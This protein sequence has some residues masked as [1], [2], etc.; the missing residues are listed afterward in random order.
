LKECGREADYV[1][2]SL[3]SDIR[4]NPLN[5][6]LDPYAQAFN[7]A[8]IITSI[9]GKGKEPFWAMLGNHFPADQN[10]FLVEPASNSSLP[11]PRIP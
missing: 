11:L 10:T 9:W 6:D 2:V 7:I 4:Y 1:D 8:S 5:N 3:D